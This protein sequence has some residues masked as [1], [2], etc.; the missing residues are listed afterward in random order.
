VSLSRW[1]LRF[2]NDTLFVYPGGGNVTLP[3]RLEPAADATWYP[4][5]EDVVPHVAA[6]VDQSEDARTVRGEVD[7]ALGKTIASRQRII[8]GADGKTRTRHARW[9]PFVTWMRRKPLY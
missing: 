1:S 2:G 4:P 3:H 6:F 9:R 5:I 8:V 7:T